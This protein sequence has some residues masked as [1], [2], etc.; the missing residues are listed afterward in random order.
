[1]LFHKPKFKHSLMSNNEYNN[2][3]LKHIKLKW[4]YE[5]ISQETLKIAELARK[6]LYQGL[7]QREQTW[8]YK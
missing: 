3:L 2:D 7:P 8:Q 1:M 6:A 4:E 5:R